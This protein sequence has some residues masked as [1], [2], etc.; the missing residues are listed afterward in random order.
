[1]EYILV[2][3]SA[4]PKPVL[5]SYHEIIPLKAEGDET[6]KRISKIYPEGSMVYNVWSYVPHFFSVSKS[7]ETKHQYS[8]KN[9]L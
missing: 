2:L 7:V 8:E 1:M 6:A 5:T 4:T 9:K 3:P